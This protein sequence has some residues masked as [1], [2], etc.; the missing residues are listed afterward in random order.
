MFEFSIKN[1][2]GEKWVKVRRQSIQILLAEKRKK[3]KIISKKNFS[4]FIRYF[5]ICL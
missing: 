5:I 2:P 3:G 4:K 1:I